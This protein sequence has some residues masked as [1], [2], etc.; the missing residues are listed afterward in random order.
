MNF[1]QDIERKRT[2]LPIWCETCDQQGFIFV[3][4]SQSTYYVICKNCYSEYS[5]AWCSECGMGGDFVGNI[6][7]HPSSWTCTDC[8][9]EFYLSSSIYSDPVYLYLEDML[10]AEIL[11][12]I[13]NSVESR[14]LPF[15]NKIIYLSL[16]LGILGVSLLT[17]FYP[18]YFVIN[19]DDLFGIES[20]CLTFLLA[21]A[22]IP[23]GA[24]L[25]IKIFNGL[26]KYLDDWANDHYV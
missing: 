14:K 21:L 2:W 6:D 12:W 5:Q 24:F 26:M 13:E 7:K 20:I 16:L 19:S 25:A 22:W 15:W 3:N 9:K 4:H 18:F 8:K 11:E 1:D 23:F 17:M 10:S